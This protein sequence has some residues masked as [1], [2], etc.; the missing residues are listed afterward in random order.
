MSVSTSASTK[1]PRR[2]KSTAEYR[3]GFDG[4]AERGRLYPKMLRQFEA[5]RLIVRADAL[6]VQGI[7]SRQHFFIHQPADDLA[8][9]EDERHLAR[10]HFQHRAR[11]LAARA[12]IAEAGIEKTRIMHAE[13]ADQ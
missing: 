6:A 3:C 9:L 13:F 7:G 2:R 10:A 12:G 5:L 8:V 11:A 1:P 4:G